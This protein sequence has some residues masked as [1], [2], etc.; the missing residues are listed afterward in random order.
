MMERVRISRK[1]TAKY[2][3]PPGLLVELADDDLFEG[4]IQLPFQ[5][6]ERRETSGTEWVLLTKSLV[7]E[8][9]RGSIQTL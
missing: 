8:L 6:P 5:I 3:D 2:W 1:T 7:K 4:V 9:E